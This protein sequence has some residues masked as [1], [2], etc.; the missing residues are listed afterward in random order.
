MIFFF[1]FLRPQAIKH[2]QHGT[3]PSNDILV[4][5]KTISHILGAPMTH[6]SLYLL[7]KCENL[8]FLRF[9][10][11]AYLLLQVKVVVFQSKS[12]ICLT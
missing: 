4:E 1:K 8:I 7:R 11:L 6:S 9:A 5:L 12:H 10:I 3:F 2:Y